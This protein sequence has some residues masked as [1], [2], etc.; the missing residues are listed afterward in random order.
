MECVYVVPRQTYGLESLKLNLGNWSRL[1]G[2]Q[3]KALRCILHLPQSTATEAIHLLSGVLPVQAIVERNSL[4]FFRSMVASKDSKESEIIN[5][6][7]AVKSSDSKS[8][9]IYIKQ[10]L[11]KYDLPSAFQLNET[12]PTKLT[13]KTQLS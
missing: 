6:Q 12:P 13:W 5:R 1:E 10:I 3:R 9:V 8:W 11:A 4:V 2:C 7:L